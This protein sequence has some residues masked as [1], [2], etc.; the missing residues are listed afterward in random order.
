MM[1]MVMIMTVV[2]DD[3]GGGWFNLSPLYGLFYIIII[4]LFQIYIAHQRE[5][6]LVIINEKNYTCT[7]NSIVQQV[8]NNIN[9]YITSVHIIYKHTRAA[10]HHYHH[11]NN[12]DDYI[13]WHRDLAL[14]CTRIMQWNDWIVEG[15]NERL[16]VPFEL[17]IYFEAFNERMGDSFE[18]WI[19]SIQGCIH[20]LRNN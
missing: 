7:C 3:D 12:S 18:T 16:F 5:F 2:V 20:L 4:L 19:C 14:V 13:P 17:Y 11:H 6:T 1:M 15:M 10:D 8:V 9:M